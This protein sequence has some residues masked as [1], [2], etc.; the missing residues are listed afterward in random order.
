MYS[1]LT[2][3]AIPASSPEPRYVYV[4]PYHQLAEGDACPA[5]QPSPGP[6]P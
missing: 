4:N 6:R 3:K 1:L 2:G 5:G